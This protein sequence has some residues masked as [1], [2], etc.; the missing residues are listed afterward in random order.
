[1][2]NLIRHLRVIVDQATGATVV[3]CARNGFQIKFS[4]AQVSSPQ[5]AIQ[6]ALG[7]WFAACGSDPGFHSLPPRAGTR[8]RRRDTTFARKPSRWRRVGVPALLAASAV[9]LLGALAPFLMAP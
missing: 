7:T 9:S 1:M 3:Q 5:N 2:D 6:L 8:R 4:A